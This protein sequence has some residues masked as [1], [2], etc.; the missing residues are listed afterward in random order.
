MGSRNA[1]H[2]W[3]ASRY[4]TSH[5]PHRARVYGE[6]AKSM[7]NLRTDLYDARVVKGLLL[8]ACNTC[9]KLSRYSQ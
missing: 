9:V 1:C 7:V 2:E 5:R 8:G 3:P 4:M 6:T